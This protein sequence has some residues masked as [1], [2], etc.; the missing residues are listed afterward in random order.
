MAVQPDR[1]ERAALDPRALD[2]LADAGRAAAR[3]GRL[4]EVLQGAVE[5]TAALTGAEVALVRVAD[6]DRGDLEVRAVAGQSRGLGAEIAGSR[7]PLGD[8][9]ETESGLAGGP[10][11]LA[12][13]AAELGLEH[14]LVVPVVAG[15]EVLG[16]LELLDEDEF[17][18]AAAAAARLAAA[19][20]ALA[21]R[22]YGGTAEPQGAARRDE[23]LRAAGE[24][25]A[26]GAD[27][28]HAQGRVLRL[29]LELTGAEGAVLWRLDGDGEA[30]RG[31]AVGR[32]DDL[33]EPPEVGVG[34]AGGRATVTNTLGEPAFGL[35]QLVFPPAFVPAP[36]LVELLGQFAIRA[37]QP[38]RAADDAHILA[39]ELEQTRAVL[40]VVAQANRELSL[41]HALDTAVDRVAELV[42]ATRLAVYL[43]EDSRLVA[44]AERGLAGPHVRVAEE[45]LALATGPF[46]ARGYVAV[47]DVSVERG[48]AP[49]ADALAEAGIEAAVALAL[50]VGGD[51]IGLLAVYPE[52][53]HPLTPNESEL[54]E[55]LAGQLAVSVQNA[56][57]H[58]RATRLGAELE[59]ALAAERASARRL[60]AQYEI[61]KAFS[62]TLRVDVT[63]DAVARTMVELLDVDAAV[64]RM[65]DPRR[66]QVQPFAL[67][68]AQEQLVAPLRSILFRPQPFGVDAI[69]R[70]FQGGE[71]IVLDADTARSLGGSHSLLVPFLE[72]GST[73]AIVPIAT[74]A[75]VLASL[76]LLSLAPDRPV[77]RE[78]IDAALSISGQAALAIDNARLYQAQKDFADAM[79]RS[80]LPQVRPGVE[81]LDIGEV[82]A[83]SAHLEIGGDLYDYVALDDG[84]LAVVLGDVTGHGVDAAADMAMAKFVF[85]TLVRE[86]PEPSDFLAAANDVVVGEIA[87]GKFI[88][89]LYLLVDPDRGDVAI[90][91]AGHPPPRLVR[92]DGTVVGIEAR[93]LALGVDEGMTYD[94]IHAELEPGG[95]VVLYTDGVI[96]ARQGDELYGIPRLDAL[97]ERRHTI[98]AEDIAASVIQSARNYTGGELFDDCAV[99]VLKRTP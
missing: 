19:Q 80:L 13:L 85:R 51:T 54:L 22:A 41:T 48:L 11:A 50:V 33:V 82:Y 86:H 1:R 36:G 63:L 43:L 69:R 94:E 46:R 38:L 66:E 14:G 17:D 34:E 49:V 4:T 25:L 24:A 16:S 71:P 73:A 81:G 62:E 44:A 52:F 87:P 60:G 40:A 35:L 57:L 45:L 10:R 3:G 79:R 76:T 58:E 9:P 32:T 8:L 55:A 68:V 23:V 28:E 47:E 72:K 31:A 59:A 5:A 93:G 15:N 27:A 89:M 77:D 37:A 92:P 74:P 42:G 64:L 83:A 67:H 61:S 98:R 70:L 99:V 97:L 95:S 78:T 88:T 30:E 29:G 84:R 12:G 75:E 20:V 65:P 91:S 2:A 96:E 21:I 7:I 56:R 18:D 90:A 39:S 26:A 53:G 6:A